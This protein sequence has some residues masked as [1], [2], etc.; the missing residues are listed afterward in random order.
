VAKVASIRVPCL[1]G[2][3]VSAVIGGEIGE[4]QVENQIARREIDGG[5]SWLRQCGGREREKYGGS[6]PANTEYRSKLEKRADAF[7]SFALYP[8]RHNPA[9]KILN[10]HR[11]EAGTET[12]ARFHRLRHRHYSYRRT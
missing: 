4:R 8:K 2:E 7:F 6:E 1:E 3:L 10:S 11:Q 12:N 9:P 5:P